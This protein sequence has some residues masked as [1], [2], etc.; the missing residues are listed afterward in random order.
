MRAQADADLKGKSDAERY[1]YY[2]E[3][4][5]PII[6]AN[7]LLLVRTQI[8]GAAKL[9]FGPAATSLFKRSGGKLEY[10]RGVIGDIRRMPLGDYYRKWL[11]RPISISARAEFFMLRCDSRA[12]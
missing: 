7:P 5:V 1:R 8:G 10:S 9:L 11:G 2:K 6:K 12:S 4:A 3:H